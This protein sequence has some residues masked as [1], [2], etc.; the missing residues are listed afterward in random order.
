VLSSGGSVEQAAEAVRSDEEITEAGR[1]RVQWLRRL[2]D[3][4]GLALR[5]YDHPPCQRATGPGGW[6]I[7]NQQTGRV[8]SVSEPS[9]RTKLSL[10]AVEA[11]LT[12]R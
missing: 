12:C 7:V 6:M 3:Q 4:Q 5:R 9:G 2:A 8:V 10:D 1:A 11:W